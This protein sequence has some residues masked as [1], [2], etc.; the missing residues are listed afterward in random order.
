MF[1]WGSVGF[2]RECPA[3]CGLSDVGWAVAP[4][5][6]GIEGGWGYTHTMDG[7]GLWPGSSVLIGVGVHRYG[8]GACVVWVLA[9]FGV[10]CGFSSFFG[11]WG[12]G[13]ELLALF[14]S[15]YLF[16]VCGRTFCW[17]EAS[18]CGVG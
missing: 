5:T 18:P 6:G 3:L 9:V 14:G 2:A 8:C 13:D 16:A 4:L 7:T 10:S 11:G 15:G 17:V 12:V 1:G